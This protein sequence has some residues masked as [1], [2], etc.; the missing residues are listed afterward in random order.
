MVNHALQKS[1]TQALLAAGLFSRAVTYWQ[2]LG[3]FGYFG[4]PESDR[5][6]QNQFLWDKSGC[7]SQDINKNGFFG[8]LSALL[9][10]T[11]R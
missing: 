7:C 10:Y 4:L 9:G 8:I 5:P 2:Q 3:W 1:H 11:V 6:W